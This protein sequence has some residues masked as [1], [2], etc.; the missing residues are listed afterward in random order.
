MSLCFVGCTKTSV[1]NTSE[2]K[3]EDKEN[4]VPVIATLEKKGVVIE[5]IDDDNAKFIL[6]DKHYYIKLSSM[7]LWP[8]GR[9]ERYNYIE[10]PPG[11]ENPFIYR[12]D[13]D[14]MVDEDTMEGMLYRLGLPYGNSFFG[15]LFPDFG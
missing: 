10:S 6:N 7:A 9:D 1:T 12:K 5:W 11:T 4:G 3:N 8:E 15:N 2:S 14:I 13:N